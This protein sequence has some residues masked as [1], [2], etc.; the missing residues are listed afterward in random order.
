MCLNIITLPVEAVRPSELRVCVIRRRRLRFWMSRVV[1]GIGMGRWCLPGCRIRSVLSSSAAVLSGSSL[2]CI[3]VMRIWPS[4][5]GE[6][7]VVSVIRRFSWST[8]WSLN[9]SLRELNRWS[10]VG[11]A[12]RKRFFL[13]C[14][15]MLPEVKLLGTRNTAVPLG[16]RSC[17]DRAMEGRIGVRV[18]VC[19][20]VVFC[21]ERVRFGEFAVGRVGYYCVVGPAVVEEPAVEQEVSGCDGE[22]E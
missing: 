2:L 6:S 8:P 12:Q 20:V 21:Y 1:V 7:F 13:T 19:E 4:L 14:W 11:V 9:T 3:S 18:S 22:G 17:T 10:A 15:N 5:L 16:R